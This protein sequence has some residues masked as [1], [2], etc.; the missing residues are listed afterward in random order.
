[1]FLVEAGT[2]NPYIQHYTT[3]NGLPSNNVYRVF[4][5]SR[6]FIWLATDAGV[7]RY[8]GTNFKY[9][10]SKDGLNTSE[11]IHIQEDSQGRIWL[12]NFNGTFNYY[13]KGRIYSG[14]NTPFLDSLQSPYVFRKMFEDNDRSLYFYDNSF[15]DVYILKNNNLVYKEKI[16]TWFSGYDTNNKPLYHRSLRYLKIQNNEFYYFSSGGLFKSKRLGEIPQ[17]VNESFYTARVFSKN[18]SELLA[19]VYQKAPRKLVLYKFR[20]FKIVDTLFT[21]ERTEDELINDVIQDNQG[22]YWISMNS[23][24]YYLKG[25]KLT[26]QINGPIFQNII[27]DHENNIWVST[28]GD[29]LYKISSYL[30]EH[31]H[32][33]T[34][35]FAE[36]GIKCTN[37]SKFDGVWAS[38]GQKLFYIKKKIVYDSGINF[39][40]GNLTQI[41]ELNNNTVVLGQP[42]FF[43]RKFINTSLD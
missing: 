12:F 11:V 4:Q 41:E 34:K 42:N 18:D 40:H 30:N 20:D 23:R 13:Y 17:S 7:A 19:E 16:P 39:D 2:Q 24:L 22:H 6:K 5:D 10:T 3:S 26:F 36:K 29:G 33:S 25:G 31:F 14:K 32:L 38:D 21:P 1:M 37:Y 9:Y 27:Q 8:D 28:L 15:G 43:I 35:N